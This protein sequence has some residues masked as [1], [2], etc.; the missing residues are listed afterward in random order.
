MIKTTIYKSLIVIAHAFVGWVFCGLVIGI[1][2][3]LTSLQ[4]ALFIHLFAAPLIFALISVI[5]YKKFNYT[6]PL[7][8][9]GIFLSLV[10]FM[11]VFI[12]APFFEKSY[13]MFTSILGIWIPFILIFLT[14]YLVGLIALGVKIKLADLLFTLVIFLLIMF[15]FLK[16]R[17]RGLVYST[18]AF[19][20]PLYFL[21]LIIWSNW[22]RFKTWAEVCLTPIKW[23]ILIF[24]Y[25]VI[26]GFLVWLSMLNVPFLIVKVSL[27][28]WL[29]GVGIIILFCGVFLAL[30]AQWQ[31]GL[32]TAILTTRIFD[33]QNQNNK[34][35]ISKGA[36]AI[37]PH[38]IFLGEHLVI[39]GCFLITGTVSLIFLLLIAFIVDL[40]A[41]RNEEK[42]LRHRFGETY[43]EY[44]SKH[45]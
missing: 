20:T 42:D 13:A 23:N 24:S 22:I 44:R 12:V 26:L 30:W 35:I 15:S 7:K 25:W 37:F 16:F 41:A 18:F 39:L 31:V 9:A 17:T 6:L 14:T 21:R 27:N 45:C 8:T 28:L 43:E 40:F 1:S 34:K 19:L 32:Q 36:Y 29:S 10:V 3:K 2:R 5:Y 4:S 38:P 11:D 33:N